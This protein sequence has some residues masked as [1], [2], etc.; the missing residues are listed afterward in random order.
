MMNYYI[1]MDQGATKTHAVV[2]NRAGQILALGQS[3]GAYHLSHGLEKQ[4]EA[5][6]IASKNAVA[7]VPG[8]DL[9]VDGF[10]AGLI[11]VDW[12][13]EQDF[14]TQ[15]VQTLN[16]AK[17]VHVVNDSY[18]ALRGGT[19]QASGVILIAG[20][21]GN[22]A[23]VSPQGE[24]FLYHYYQEDELQGGT[25]LGRAA[26]KAIYRSATGRAPLT[27]LTDSVLT[28]TNTTNVDALL[29]LDVEKHFPVPVSQLA[30]LVFA[31]ADCHD[32][33]AI[34]I[35]SKFAA[36]LAELVTTG[37]QRFAMTELAIEVVVSGSIFKTTNPILLDTLTQHI[38]NI[39]PRAKLVQA[40]Y[41]PVIGAAMLALEKAGVIITPDIQQN[42]EKTSAA[43]GLI[44]PGTISAE[45]FSHKRSLS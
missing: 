21:G 10:Y 11:G 38:H 37:L 26:L 7:Q 45:T 6:K 23:I 35:I 25:A 33:V 27:C 29:R 36:G 13:D 3:Q 28:F 40:R 34:H 2:C 8:A 12:P 43:L 1:G 30:P 24:K 44:R 19:S 31:A 17:D 16:L 39:A 15:K 42:I 18:A 22:C 4:L 14:L 5:I 41:E 32:K 9:P 20:T